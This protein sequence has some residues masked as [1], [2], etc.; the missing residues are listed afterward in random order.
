[1]PDDVALPDAVALPGVAIVIAGVLKLASGV[2][3]STRRV[4]EE[5]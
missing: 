5:E 3:L 1:M 2:V 4:T